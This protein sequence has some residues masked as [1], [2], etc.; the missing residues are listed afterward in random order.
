MEMKKRQSANKNFF[1]VIELTIV[2]A[3]III[4]LVMLLPAFHKITKGA[5]VEMAARTFGSELNAVRNYAISHRVY[6][7]LIMYSDN[8]PSDYRYSAFRPCIVDNSNVFQ[9]WVYGEKWRFFPTGVTI[10]NMENAPNR[11]ISSIDCSDIGGSSNFSIADDVIIFSPTGKLL[12]QMASP[13]DIKIGD[14]NIRTGATT[15]NSN[16]INVRI[17]AYTGRVSYGND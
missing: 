16:Q 3:I 7:A 8:L 15:D 17:G 12:G 14:E 9:E 10:L 6:V 1:S 11:T 4:M 5:N 2:L 13:T